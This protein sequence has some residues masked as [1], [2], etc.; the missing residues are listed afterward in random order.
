MWVWLIPILPEVALLAALTSHRARRHFEQMGRRRAVA[1]TLLGL[2]SLANALLL[3]AVFASLVHGDEKSG[4][5]LLLMAMTVWG[6]N[7]LTAMPLSR[8]AKLLMR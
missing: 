5:R 2:I 8:R 4:P 6:T 7:V 1:L 3:F